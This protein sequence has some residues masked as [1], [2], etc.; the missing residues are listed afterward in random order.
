MQLA[1]PAPANA[2]VAHD[3]AAPSAEVVPTTL[4]LFQPIRASREDD[5]RTYRT[6]L[7]TMYPVLRNYSWIDEDDLD[8]ELDTRL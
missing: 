4:R 6:W 7:H 5:P 1:A 2:I 8:D 3:L